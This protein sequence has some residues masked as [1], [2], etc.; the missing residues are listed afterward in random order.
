MAGV[1][2]VPSQRPNTRCTYVDTPSPHGSGGKG[3]AYTQNTRLGSERLHVFHTNEDVD[4]ILRREK[5]IN[6]F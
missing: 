2:H 3:R 6:A 4:L 5:Q 1:T